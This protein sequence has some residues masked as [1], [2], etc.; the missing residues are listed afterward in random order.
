MVYGET[1]PEG[2]SVSEAPQVIGL[3]LR[4]NVGAAGDAIVTA[5][6]ASDGP[7]LHNPPEEK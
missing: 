4:V 1:P 3:E 5:V 7:E 6:E 2:V